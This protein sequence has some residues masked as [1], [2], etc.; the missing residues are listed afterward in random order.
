MKRTQ[1]AQ[2]L[3]LTKPKELSTLIG[4]DGFRDTIIRL[5]RARTDSIHFEP[6]HLISEFAARLQEAAGKSANIELSIQ[7]MKFGGNAPICAVAL[8]SL[9]FAPVLIGAL[10]SPDI[11]PL[12][13]PV[14][15]ACKKTY[16]LAPPALTDAIEF[17]D[18]KIMLGK[19]ESVQNIN[20]ALLLE[21]IGKEKLISLFE[22]CSLF[23]TNNWSIILGLTE[24]WQFISQ[25]IMPHLTPK[26][27]SC[28][29]DLTDPSKRSD[30]DL[31]YALEAIQE[32]KKG[33]RI[34]LGLNESEALR[35]LQFYGKITGSISKQELIESAQFIMKEAQ[36]DEVIIHTLKSAGGV[37]E[38][39]AALVD[40]PYCEKPK[41]STGGG[42]NFNAG[43]LAAQGFNL[44]LQ[45]ALLMGVATSG[46]YVRTGKS[47]SLAELIQFLRAWDQDR[48]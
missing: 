16:S 10:G 12:F 39:E 38:T 22:E 43:F 8:S 1:L 34:T 20:R 30:H 35:I 37:N 26:P 36:L 14:V 7:E 17:D 3:A 23:V 4:F 41:L 9:G 42:D 33:F 5:V 19:H 32:L 47:P 44:T 13:E 24:I 29:I 28:F 31:K 27:R 21:K 46:T 25:E 2:K 15:Q 11:D 40:G 45:E 6:F 48:I 18:G